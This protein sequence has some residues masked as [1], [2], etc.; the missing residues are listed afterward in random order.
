VEP[1]TRRR[2]LYDAFNARDIT[3]V[4]AALTDDVDRPKEEH[5]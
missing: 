5:A 1:E 4:L 2:D 3:G